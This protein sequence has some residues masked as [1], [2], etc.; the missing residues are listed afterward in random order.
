LPEESVC[1]GCGTR[2]PLTA[3]FCHVCGLLL[4]PLT[5]VPTAA[6]AGWPAQPSPTGGPPVPGYG[7]SA[8][9]STTTPGRPTGIAVLA[10]VELVT[11]L[12]VLFVIYDF[13]Y[14]ANWEFTYGDVG[15]GA[16]DA[17]MAVG[18]AAVAG[19]AVMAASRLWSMQA[20]AWRLAVGLAVGMISLM[21]VSTL[22]WSP[23]PSDFVGATA[24]L[25]GLAYLNLSHVRPL[26]GRRPLS[27]M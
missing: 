12:V 7:G 14:W 27:F 18:W 6:P 2:S 11:C 22:L 17:L 1:A 21:A 16:V 15:W 3:Q 9:Q 20:S 10:V 13:G 26:F 23:S 25:C 8:G 24:Q 5:P 19:T 4:A